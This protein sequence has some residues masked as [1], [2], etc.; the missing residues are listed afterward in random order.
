MNKKYYWLL[1]VPVVALLVVVGIGVWRNWSRTGKENKPAANQYRAEQP[2]LY[3]E[4]EVDKNSDQARMANL[5]ASIKNF[6][7]ATSFRSVIHRPFEGSQLTAQV[8]YAKPLRMHVLM[9]IEDK[10]GSTELIIVGE[11]IYMKDE[12]G[13]WKIVN[14]E[15]VRQFGRDFFAGMLATEQT[16]TSFGVPENASMTYEQNSDKDC[17]EAKTQYQAE[18]GMRDISFC[19]NDK[20]ELVYVWIQ[21]KDGDVLTEY[22]DFNQLIT[23]ERP[24]LPLLERRLEIVQ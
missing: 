10:K 21:A 13:N 4:Q 23:V 22:Q 6:R 5:N 14:D 17:L 2:W 11:T 8:E 1:A 3:P 18:D 20:N 12:N 19:F 9:Q 7:A 24:P 15:T 16:L